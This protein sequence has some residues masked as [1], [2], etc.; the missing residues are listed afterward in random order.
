MRPTIAYLLGSVFPSFYE[1]PD[2]FTEQQRELAGTTARR[3]LTFAWQHQ[4]RD[5]WLI[6]RALRGVCRTFESNSTGSAAL[7]RH[8]LQPGHVAQYGYEELPWLAREV[9][10]LVRFDPIL[11]EDIYTCVC[12]YQER[13]TEITQ[14]GSGR[15][16]GLTSTHK[17][18]YEGAVEELAEAYPEFLR[19]APIHATRA[20]VV[21]LA[22]YV[23]ERHRPTSGEIPED[24]FEYDGR[25]AVL[26]TDYSS[27]WDAG[28]T[29]HHD[30][31]LQMLNAFEHY[32]RDLYTA[33]D[34]DH[35]RRAIVEILTT[36]NRFAVLWRRL[37]LWGAEAPQTLGMDLRSLAWARPILIAYDTR[38]AAGN[39][40]TALFPLLDSEDCRRIEQAILSIPASVD[41]EPQEVA[42]RER[43]RLLSCLPRESTVT[44]EGRQ[45][46][47]QLTEQGEILSN[48]GVSFTNWTYTGAYGEREHLIALG[49][50]IEAVPNRRI[51]ELEQP[52][53]AFTKD[54]L[55]AAPSLE[56][57]NAV[58][59]ALHALYAALTT[60]EEDGVDP[61]QQIYGWDRLAEA[62]ACITYLDA[63]SCELGAGVF[64]RS[65]LLKAAC[66]PDPLPDPQTD[67]SFDE[68]TSWGRPAVRIGAAIGLTR[69][70]RHPT[71]LNTAVTE[72][73]AT[74]SCDD[75]PA[76]RFQVAS[77]LHSLYHTV[78]DLMWSI[79]ERM[80]KEERRRS[81]LQGL[82]AG[83]LH[84]LAGPHGHRVANLVQIVLDRV[85]DGPGAQKV[86]E[87]CVS[88]LTGLYVWQDN[89][90]GR[91]HVFSIAD[92]PTAFLDDAQR[93]VADLRE[94]LKYGPVRTSR[95]QEDDIR[96]RAF[97]LME[98]LL[99]STIPAFRAIET[100]HNVSGLNAW[101]EDEQK[102]LKDLA[103]IADAVGRELY[104]ASGA[105]DQKGKG[106]RA[107]ALVD[108]EE[109]R[110]FFHEAATL[111]SVLAE[112]G[113]PKIVHHLVQTLTF[114]AEAE[115]RQVFLLIGRILRAGKAYGYHYESLAAGVIVRLVEQYLAEYRL[116]L[117]E[118]EECRRVLLE[119]LD[120]FVEAG[121]P[122]ARRLAYRLEEIFR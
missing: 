68:H 93:M 91:E 115:P 111:F 9:K 44:E 94:V 61:Q 95:T 36:Q 56:V 121:W 19:I 112:L 117:R 76:V 103:R 90:V 8:C 15:L 101:T 30:A 107:G 52:V 1:Q 109:K 48:D 38:V 104:F 79:V 64:V 75:V 84:T 39:F 18:D 72:A 45:R 92:H 87:A 63:L 122:E 88:I 105:F 35:T 10:R 62:C 6:I 99:A 28:S 2:T 13:S 22:A 82:L 25:A 17:Q 26:R 40:L 57:A 53:E 96:Q 46:L 47:Q 24:H 50:S 11:V 16:L 27:I 89:H 49:V 5:E 12:M 33:P 37:L 120:T 83:P 110:R 114:L 102:Q 119:I 41:Q 32:L 51:Q 85:V 98:R 34:K 42:L 78:P 100:A 81:I 43:D 4:P 80:C 113:F 7:L 106:M 21:I 97:S 58:L 86:R 77:R 31:A 71:C 118:N 69:L 60:A 14:M 3:L 29:Y 20:L 73:I 23:A 74:L 67:A 54:Y 66:H 70:A 55:N 65:V 108:V 59:P 116:L